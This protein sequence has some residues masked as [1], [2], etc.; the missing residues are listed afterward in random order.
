MYTV[1]VTD[2]ALPRLRA[3]TLEDQRSKNG[4]PLFNSLSKGG[5]TPFS[6]RLANMVALMYKRIRLTGAR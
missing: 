3:L 1:R 6:G 2:H 5:E 4:A